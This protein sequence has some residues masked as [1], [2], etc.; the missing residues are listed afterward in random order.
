MTKLRL[1]II[2]AIACLG[3]L[4]LCSCASSSGDIVGEY[5]KIPRA[6]IYWGYNLNISPDNRYELFTTTYEHNI[7]S[8]GKIE[9]TGASYRMID[10][11]ENKNAVELINCK[12]EDNHNSDYSSIKLV[13]EGDS[14]K[15]YY[16]A[17]I[18]NDKRID[19]PDRL[20]ADYI[21]TGLVNGKSSDCPYVGN[22]YSNSSICTIREVIN[23]LKFIVG[24]SLNGDFTIPVLVESEDINLERPVRIGEQL[25][26]TL[27]IKE[28]RP[29]MTDVVINPK[30][31]KIELIY[32]LAK[33][34]IET[35][36]K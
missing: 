11:S 18:I 9:K 30:K 22:Y 4:L 15:K 1:H 5:H 12:V 32:P 8:T 20:Y 25:Y 24:Y 3:L 19:I 23:K 2:L 34:Y 7:V 6:G 16:W 27:R 10:D 28:L 31:N 17:P 13:I 33:D 36:S 26:I 35:L 29:C 14:T 21:V